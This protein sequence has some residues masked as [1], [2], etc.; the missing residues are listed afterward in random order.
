[1]FFETEPLPQDH[2][3]W[4]NPHITIWPHVA[5]QTNPE[6]ASEQIA[7][8]L[9]AFHTGTTPENQIHCQKGY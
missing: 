2:A 8:A 9:W 5:A 6:T 4:D 3:F 1:M 7:H